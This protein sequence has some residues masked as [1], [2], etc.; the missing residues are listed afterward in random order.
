LALLNLA[1]VRGIQARSGG[2]RLLSQ[3]LMLPVLT[4]GRPK[5]VEQRGCVASLK[6]RRGVMGHRRILT[7][8]RGGRITRDGRGQG[9]VGVEPYEQPRCGNVQGTRKAEQHQHRNIVQ[10][11]FDVADIS[12]TYARSDGE[13]PLGQPTLLPVLA[14]GRSK[15][16]QRCVLRVW[17]T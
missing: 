13:C 3:T 16:L 2:E 11:S 6:G 8:A 5:Q 17:R 7:S 12:I 10:T 1:H 14:E 15:T 4:Q 9:G